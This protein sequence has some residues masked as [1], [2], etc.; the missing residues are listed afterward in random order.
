MS[1]VSGHLYE[2]RLVLKIVAETGRDPVTDEP[3]SASDLIDVVPRGPG[4]PRPAEASSVPALLR[5]LQSEWDAVALE[6]HALRSALHEARKELAATLYQHDAATRVIARLVRERDEARAA[7]RSAAHAAAQEAE[8][9]AE[10]RRSEDAEA[11][12]AAERT[13]GAERDEDAAAAAPSKPS[14]RAKTDAT[15][16]GEAAAPSP[17]PLSSEIASAFESTSKALSKARKKRP[18]PAGLVSAEAFSSLAPLATL[19]S[20]KT[21]SGGVLALAACFSGIAGLPDASE[22]Q[23]QQ[24]T[25]SLVASGGAD[26]RI[27]VVDAALDLA[28]S[29]R[30]VATLSHAPGVRVAALGWGLGGALLASGGDDGIVQVWKRESEGNGDGNDDE[31]GSTRSRDPG[32]LDD[33]LATLAS[34][35]SSSPFAPLVGVSVH[36]SSSYLFAAHADATWRLWDLAAGR[37]AASLAAPP[38]SPSEPAAA[39][40]SASLHPDGLL[41]ATGTSDG[42]VKIWEVRAQAPIATLQGPQPPASPSPLYAAAPITALAFSENGYHLASAGGGGARTWDLRKLAPLAQLASPLEAETSAGVTALAFDAS[43]RYLAA[44]EGRRVGIYGAKQSWNILGHVDALA[45]KGQARNVAWGALAK[46]I[47]VGGGDHN[48]RLFKVGE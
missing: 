20:H 30:T 37:C 32:F 28:P 48:L 43:G 46:T 13:Q 12:S 18:A 38:T 33:P 27:A 19:P 8:Q 2:K 26:G 44:T 15:P 42:L 47:V 29:A 24:Q 45:G 34:S 10:Q 4:A 36:P 5:T 3:L 31:S 39:F 9:E 23:Q 16:A 6:T 25:R 35:P 41:Y 11:A 7:A 1:R 21:R 17:A 22:P 14:K 40:A